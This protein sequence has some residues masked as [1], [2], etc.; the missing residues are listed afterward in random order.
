MA[1]S[2]LTDKARRLLAEADNLLQ[3]VQRQI[4]M[5]GDLM[6]VGALAG[7]LAYLLPQILEIPAVQ[8]SEIDVQVVVMTSEEALVRL[9]SS[10]L[11][12]GIVAL[13][14]PTL[15]GLHV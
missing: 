4:A 6:R 13:P 8:H 12:I 2:L 10:N 14:P 7:A 5:P 15:C 11:D 3:T 9:V 1:G